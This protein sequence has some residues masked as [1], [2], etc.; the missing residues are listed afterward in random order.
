MQENQITHLLWTFLLLTE[1]DMA[2]CSRAFRKPKN[3]AEERNLTENAIPMSTRA[4]TKWSVKI[5][6]E[7]QNGRKNKNPAIEPCAFTTGKSKVH[8][9][10]TDLAS[11]TTES[12]NFLADKIC[13]RTVQSWSLQCCQNNEKSQKRRLLFKISC[14]KLF[15]FLLT[16]RFKETCKSWWIWGRRRW[17]RRR[18]E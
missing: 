5:F 11:M 15:S 12:R 9:L 1:E 3:A 4:V 2:S 16:P 6:L 8:R 7:W 18:D 13:R 14:F 10:D 17:T